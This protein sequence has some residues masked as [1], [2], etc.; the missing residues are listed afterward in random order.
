MKKII[1]IGLCIIL[2]SCASTKKAV[3]ESVKTETNAQ[4]ATN[5]SIKTEMF[6]D[7]TKTTTGKVTITEI[8]F[9][10][11]DSA[12]DGMSIANA[13]GII[14]ANNGITIGNDSRV[15]HIRQTI[16][17]NDSESKGQS[18]KT[19]NKA[20][21]QKAT[22]AQK[23]KSNINSTTKPA[24]DPYRWRYIFYILA[25]LIA[26]AIFIYVRRKPLVDKFKTILSQVK[27]LL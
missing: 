1:A 6:V 13:S 5:E 8:E 26:V 16:I 18:R 12:R 9:F 23:S 20:I 11:K 21:N 24:P 10:P 15:K 25:I 14:V 2:A 3:N 22:I 27:K 4:I 19:K 17:E 7:T